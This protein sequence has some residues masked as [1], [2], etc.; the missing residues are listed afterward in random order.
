MALTELPD[1]EPCI[2]WRGAPID[3]LVIVESNELWPLWDAAVRVQ[4]RI[5]G[6]HE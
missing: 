6:E 4:D 2:V 1:P 3:G 5:M